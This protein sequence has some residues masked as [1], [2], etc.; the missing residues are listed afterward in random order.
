MW[1]AIP[2]LVV[3]CIVLPGAGDFER[4]VEELSEA[5]TNAEG[6]DILAAIAQ[7]IADG[8]FP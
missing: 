1:L 7:E 6:E 5:T 2:W 4:L 3:V 8:T